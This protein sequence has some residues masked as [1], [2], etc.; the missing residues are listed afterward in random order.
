MRHVLTIG[1]AGLMLVL[2]LAAPA[3]SSPDSFRRDLGAL[4]GY[5]RSVAE[6]SR[7]L[8]GGTVPGHTNTTPWTLRMPGGNAGYPAF[9]V[10][11]SAMMLGAGLIEPDEI[12]G[13]IRLTASVQAG[14]QGDTR[15][16]GL[17]APPYSIPDHITLTGSVCWFPGAYDGPDQGDGSFGFLPPADD[18]FYLI[19][20]VRE[21]ARLTGNPDLLAA[22]M[23]TS[24]A[25]SVPLWLICERAFDSV[26]VDEHG[27]VVCS[28]EKGRTRVDWG[29][30][31]GIHKTGKALMPSLLRWRA[32]LDLSD[33][34]RMSGKSALAEQYAAEAHRIQAAIAPTFYRETEPD[35]AMLLSTTGL[36]AKEDV[37]IAAYAV[38]LDVLPEKQ[39]LALARRLLALYRAG[40]TVEDGQIRHLPAGQNW[41][42]SIPPPGTYQN[43]AFWGTPSGWFI[44]AMGR[45]DA[46]AAGAV[47]ADLVRHIQEHESEGAP[48]ECVNSATG[49]RRNSLYAASVCL[50]Y[51]ALLRDC[52]TNAPGR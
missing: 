38:W 34:F 4:R 6:S 41:E 45:V 20:M 46:D 23:K 36:G 10:R 35:Q 21:H 39:T 18:A 49:Y 40:G 22:P 19:Q 44:H 30:C 48:W 2:F 27:L 31:D 12:E 5:A 3:E 25:E 51:A 43:G 16:N 26:E 28:A 7:I 1:L 50:P 52:G 9:W 17:Y 37:W 42:D 32:A 13:W 15:A 24:Y 11:D 29:F 8:P 47:L 33:L 14:P